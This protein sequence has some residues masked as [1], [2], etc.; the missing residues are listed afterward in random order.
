MIGHRAGPGRPVRPTAPLLAVVLALA[1]LMAVAGC[2]GSVR[3]TATPRPPSHGD[4]SHADTSWMHDG[5]PGV[6]HPAQ[7]AFCDTAA[8]L[9]TVSRMADRDSLS[10]AKRSVTLMFAIVRKAA[11]QAPDELAEPLHTILD[12][13]AAFNDSVQRAETQEDLTDAAAA[14]ERRRGFVEASEEVGDYVGD[15]C[16][17]TADS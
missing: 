13:Y 6:H 7:S 17:T 4:R 11:D 15:H 8:D 10:T 9:Q 16:S 14:L 1:V 12:S 3:V 5:I 2:G